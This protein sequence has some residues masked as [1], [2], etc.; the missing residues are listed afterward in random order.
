MKEQRNL[1]FEDWY[2]IVYFILESGNVC[3]QFFN[4]I[5]SVCDGLLSS[6][7]LRRQSVYLFHLL[8]VPTATLTKEETAI[9]NIW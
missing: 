2:G 6:N 7:G 3:L 5:V 4:L 8:L 9:L 1:C